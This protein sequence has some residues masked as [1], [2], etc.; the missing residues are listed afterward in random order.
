[1]P[2]PIGSVNKVRHSLGIRPS[3]VL[4]ILLAAAALLAPLAVP[5]RA[6]APKKSTYAAVDSVTLTA[7]P[8]AGYV[9]DYWSG[10]TQDIIANPDQNPVSFVMGDRPDNDRT[11]TANFVQSDI[12]YAVTAAPQTAGSGS[13]TLQPLPP[14]DGY[15]INQEVSARA[16]PAAGYVFNR[17]SGA[18]GG[19]D[20]P[21][22]FAMNE[23][24]AITAIFNAIVTTYCSP[25]D[26][27][28]VTL[29]PAQP[30]NGYAADTEVAIS[31]KANKGYRFV[32][33]EGDASGSDRSIT[34][35]VDE[36][37]TITARFAEQSPSPW[38]LWVIIVLAGLF[39][40]LILVRLVYARMNRGALDEPPEPDD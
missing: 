9:F 37:K 13:V 19:T 18:I 6:D 5:A 23:R 30:S 8:L 7:V 22:S 4:V 2:R 15:P 33:W 32:S 10:Q 34:V 31:A 12:R 40:A 36:P 11:I 28:Q 25:S 35:T 3:W 1:V 39:G 26:A 21:P 29:G 27:G 14:S 17:W 20:N 24:K 38:W 16:V